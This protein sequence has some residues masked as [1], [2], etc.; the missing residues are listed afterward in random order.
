MNQK[1]VDFYVL[2]LDDFPSCK[3]PIYLL[4][5]SPAPS[6]GMRVSVRSFVEEHLLLG[7]DFQRF[8]RGE[9]GRPK[10]EAAA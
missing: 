10:S 5:A 4:L 2:R 1:P 8:A 9:F 3:Y 7:V 6:K